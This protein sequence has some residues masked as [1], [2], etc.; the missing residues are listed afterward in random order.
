MYVQCCVGGCQKQ[1]SLHVTK[2]GTFLRQTDRRFK[3]KH[4]KE[5]YFN[6]GRE[7]SPSSISSP[8]GSASHKASDSMKPV[9]RINTTQPP[10]NVLSA[11]AK[12]YIYFP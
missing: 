9:G 7:T 5:N 12:N 2:S 3:S 10:K 6:I 4:D 11:L 1:K 8:F